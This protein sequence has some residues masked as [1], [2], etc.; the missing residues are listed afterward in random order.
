MK[1]LFKFVRQRM[2]ATEAEGL[3]RMVMA[4]VLPAG[5]MAL[6]RENAIEVFRQAHAQGLISDECYG[7]FLTKQMEELKSII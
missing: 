7:D 1:T 5:A 2:S 4:E 6:E 3:Q